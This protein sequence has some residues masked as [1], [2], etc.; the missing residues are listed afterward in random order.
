MSERLLRKPLMLPDTA[1]LHREE[2][3]DLLGHSEA[4]FSPDEAYRYLLIRRWASGGRTATFLMLNPSTADAAQD[5]PTIRRCIA[6]ARRERCN[7]LT[8]V[9]L[10][11]LRATDPMKVRVHDEPVG[12]SNDQFID[13]H[14]L[15]G[16]LVVA[17]WGANGQIRG[18]DLI[19]TSRLRAAGVALV[20]LGTTVSGQPRHPLRLAADTPFIP[21]LPEGMAA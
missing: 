2:T 11:G 6:Y 13:E 9:N 10:F 18:R 3:R 21:Y 14:C 5:D 8:V 4:V 7:A 15:P 19:V 12:D 17:A 1:P 16:Q 20:C